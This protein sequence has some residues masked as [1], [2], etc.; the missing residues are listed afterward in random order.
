MYTDP[1]TCDVLLVSTRE[2]ARDG[3]SRVEYYCCMAVLI[4]YHS[5]ASEP[6]SLDGGLRSYNGMMSRISIALDNGV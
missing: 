6:A 1:S 3:V 2:Y 5:L 4:Y